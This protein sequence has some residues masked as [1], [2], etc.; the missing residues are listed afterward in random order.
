[1]R[2]ETQQSPLQPFVA[3]DNNNSSVIQKIGLP[4]DL[5]I[6]D[7]IYSNLTAKRL[8]EQ[9]LP[10]FEGGN[11]EPF[12]DNDD[13]L[14]QDDSWSLISDEFQITKETEEV[15]LLSIDDSKSPLRPFKLIGE[16]KISTYQAIGLIT[17]LL[18]THIDY[19]DLEVHR[20]MS[21]MVPALE[22]GQA[23]VFLN[24]EYRPYG[25][26][27]WA[28]LSDDEHNAL[29]KGNFSKINDPEQFFS[30][31]EAETTH[32][33][34]FDLVSPFNEPNKLIE[35]LRHEFINHS[36]AFLLKSFN[37]SISTEQAW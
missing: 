9:T 32:L 36:E 1:M 34:L 33:W 8:I 17:D 20:C 15:F 16:K 14:Y 10:A 18:M 35:I 28:Y 6:N 2:L 5:A 26:A 31:E 22:H 7:D 12:F 4:S 19:E 27:S 30:N 21:R 23:K 25:Y 24:A 37:E 3:F 29:K 13:R 11:C